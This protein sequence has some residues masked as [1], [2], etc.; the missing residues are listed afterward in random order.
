MFYSKPTDV[1]WSHTRWP[2]FSA[3][4]IACKH[5]GEVYLDIYA[6]DMIQSLRRQLGKIIIL[7]SAHRCALHNV[8]VG[9]APRSQHK[10]LA[11]D[12]SLKN[13]NR[14]ELK[15]AAKLLGFTGFGY[16]QTFLH[17]DTRPRPAEWFYGEKSR[18]LWTS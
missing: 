4:E 16:A 12:V 8:Q 13:H 11:F 9:G 14:Q 17:L 10:K 18:Q 2:N 7:N 15:A 3:R 5:C 6:M 1:E